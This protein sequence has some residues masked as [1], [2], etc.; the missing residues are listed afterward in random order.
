MSLKVS[1]VRCM[2]W[3]LVLAGSLGHHTK[4]QSRKQ[5][6]LGDSVE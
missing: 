6:V 2:T 1:I 5:R 3:F 4:D